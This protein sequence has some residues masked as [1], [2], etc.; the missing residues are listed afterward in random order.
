MK[1]VFKE[2]MIRKLPT[3]KD[4]LIK[5][6]IITGALLLS[7]LSLV[8][9][10]SI[11][12]M[13]IGILGFIIY[14]IFGYMKKEFEYIFTNGELDIDCIYGKARRKRKFTGDVKEAILLAHSANRDAE[15]ELKK[16]EVTLDFGSGIISEKSWYLLTTHTGK[17]TK[18]IFEPNDNMFAAMKPFIPPRKIFKKF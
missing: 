5:C 3:A 1:D 8:F 18:I 15:T 10:P 13:V 16:A 12:I 2:Q 7:F 17:R 6:A 9:I 11:A 4:T 14:Y